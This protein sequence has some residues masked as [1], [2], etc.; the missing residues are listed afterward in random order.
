MNAR[1][2]YWRPNGGRRY[3]QIGT[4]GGI[5]LIPIHSVHEAATAE[6]AAIVDVSEA[7][8]AVLNATNLG[9]AFTVERTYLTVQDIRNVDGLKITIVPSLLA[10]E[11]WDIKPSETFDW[12]VSV[13]IRKRVKPTPE[14]VDPLMLLS[15]NII[16]LFATK[17]LGHMRRGTRSRCI[18]VEDQPNYDPDR[19]DRTGI[20]TSSIVFTFR[21]I[22]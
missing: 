20:Y 21:T 9:Q 4:A 16:R 2:I 12:Q 13:W 14:E 10:V 15:Q 11:A 19:I 7:M 5:S 8:V 22:L 3:P 1:V 18:R 6:R 17:Q